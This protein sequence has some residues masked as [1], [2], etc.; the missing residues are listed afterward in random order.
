MTKI[1]TSSMKP[2]MHEKLVHCEWSPRCDE[3]C[4]ESREGD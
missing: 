4:E 3:C 2:K 1:G